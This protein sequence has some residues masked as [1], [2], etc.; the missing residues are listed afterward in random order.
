MLRA[1]L[2]KAVSATLKKTA[3]KNSAIVRLFVRLNREIKHFT[4]VTRLAFFVV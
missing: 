3:D 1:K 4:K 2:M